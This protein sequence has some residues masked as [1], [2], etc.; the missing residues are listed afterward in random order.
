MQEVRSM[1]RFWRNLSIQTKMFSICFMIIAFMAVTIFGYL[2]PQV[3]ESIINTKKGSLDDI[4]TMAINTIDS[5]NL[6]YQNKKISYDEAIK[7]S[8]NYVRSIRYGT[9]SKDYLWINDMKPVMLMHP[10]NAALENKNVGNLKDAHGKEFFKE[11]IDVVKAKGSGFVTYMW[12]WKDNKNLIVPKISYI[13]EYKPFG[14][15]VGTGL[16]LIDVENQVKD[17]LNSLY[18]KMGIATLGIIFATITIILL[19]S[20]QLRKQLSKTMTFAKELSEGDF[21]KRID[22]GQKDEFGQ[23]GTALNRSADNLEIL[24]SNV[25]AAS[26][27]LAQ[28][29]EQIASGN[30]S[31]SQRTAEQASSIEEI[32]STIEE[33]SATIIQNAENAREANGMADASTRM[34]D[35]GG[36]LVAEAVNAINEISHSS[37]KIFEIINVINEISFQTNLLAL[38]AAVE[39]ARAGESGRGFAVVAGE[40]RNLAQRSGSAAKEIE[41]LI[42]ESLDKIDTGT[43]K[44]NKSG[45]ALNE[46]ITSVKGVGGMIAEIATGSQQQKE[47][48]TQINVAISEMDSMTQRNAALV[49]ETAAASEEMANQ[50]QELLAMMEKFKINRER[51]S[52]H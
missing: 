30:A 10:Y 50:S 34:A 44:A 21:T 8:M 11:M 47:G 17:E 27:N 38:N 46:I 4:V 15:V 13:K 18:I 35:N 2:M 31:L 43:E 49:E 12:E 42:K 28:A 22:V 25:I 16:Y 23:L 7:K 14:W 40:V 33:T 20:V 32:A 37:K 39:A 45:H 29:V 48:I 19:F 51:I 26:H 3:K 1:L 24:I 52:D 6:E 9:D 36:K 41:K 5:F